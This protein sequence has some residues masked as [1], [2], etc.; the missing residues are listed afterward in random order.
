M[1]SGHVAMEGPV[2]SRLLP[3]PEPNA[4]DVLLIGQEA[5]MQF[6]GNRRIRFRVI[7]VDRKPT[8]DGW[9][10]LTGYV[11][12]ERGYAA[13]RREIFV[14]RDGLYLLAKRQST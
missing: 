5:S 3:T 8:Y 6:A 4:G 7:S 1:S 13:E 12:D 11:I 10:W 14:Q 2:D 9:I